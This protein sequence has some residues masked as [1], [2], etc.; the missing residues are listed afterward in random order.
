VYERSPCCDAAMPEGGR[1]AVTFHPMAIKAPGEG[2]GGGGAQ[3]CP[4]R[5]AFEF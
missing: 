2:L 5:Q 4:A 3:Q 1:D